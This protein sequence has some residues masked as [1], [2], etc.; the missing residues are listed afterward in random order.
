MLF[1]GHTTWIVRKVSE[2][3]EDNENIAS[4]L[5]TTTYWT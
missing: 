2:N 3:F 1:V 5:P 4:R